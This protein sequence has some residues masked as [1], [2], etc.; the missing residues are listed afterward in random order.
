MLRWLIGVALIAVLK[1]RTNRCTGGGGH[2]GFSGFT[3]P[4]PPAPVNRGVR[5]QERKPQ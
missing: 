1:G 2:D 5:P 4:R 3:A